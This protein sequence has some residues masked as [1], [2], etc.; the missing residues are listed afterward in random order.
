[1][2]GTRIL[3]LEPDRSTGMRMCKAFL[4]ITGIV[5]AVIEA[6]ILGGGGVDDEDEGGNDG[7]ESVLGEGEGET[8]TGAG[9]GAGAGCISGSR[10]GMGIIGGGARGSAS[11]RTRFKNTGCGTE[12]TCRPF[13]GW[14]RLG[15]SSPAASS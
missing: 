5:Q 1:M 7:G 10:T 3:L 2:A 11:A 6:Y 15:F 4:S 12:R 9:A 13:S 14:R 8:G